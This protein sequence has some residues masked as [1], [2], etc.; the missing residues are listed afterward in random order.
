MLADFINFFAENLLIIQLISFFISVIFIGFS[1]YFIIK[2]NL[3]GE[4]LKYYREVLGG[5]NISK[6]RTLKI[7]KRIQQRLK[8][9]KTEQLKLA[10]LEAD[11]I[12]DEILK[13]AGYRGKNLEERLSFI[14]VAQL[15]NIEEIKRAHKLKERII[16]EPDL[17]ITFDEARAII[18]IYKKALQELNLI[19]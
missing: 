8:T 18:D 12:L 2:I 6:R 13:M 4:R 5:V 15:S 10:I 7:W 17:T 16:S 19:E 11:K 1:I 3:A 14:T 9:G